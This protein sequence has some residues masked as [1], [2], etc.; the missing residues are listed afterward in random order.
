MS[1]Y[2]GT[3]LMTLTI[4]SVASDVDGVPELEIAL[5][6]EITMARGPVLADD[7][8]DWDTMG[9]NLLQLTE[10]MQ[11]I[12]NGMSTRAESTGTSLTL[13]EILRNL[14]SI[15][16][17]ETAKVYEGIDWKTKVTVIA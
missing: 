2:R 7:Q 15:L 6:H 5:E 11:A 16:P 10:N 13:D 3:G 14:K 9:A 4:T 17:G 8:I 12:V 1:G